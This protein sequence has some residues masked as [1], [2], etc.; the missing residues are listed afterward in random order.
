MLIANVLCKFL[1]ISE[2]HLGKTQT[3]NSQWKKKKEKKIVL[4]KDSLKM[5]LLMAVKSCLL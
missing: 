4:L 1:T 2:A 5:E 3:I